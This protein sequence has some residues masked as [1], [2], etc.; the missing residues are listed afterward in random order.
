MTD[1]AAADL[2]AEIERLRA[3]VE[4]LRL[5][6]EAAEAAADHDVLTPALNRRGF[7]AAM[8]QTMAYC[9]RYDAPA[10]LLYLDLDGFKPVNDKHGH[11]AGDALL[12]EVARRLDVCIQPGD[13]AFRIGGDEFVVLLSRVRQRSDVSEV[14]RRLLVSL[15]EPY[16]LDTATVSIGASIGIAFAESSNAD[17]DYLAS[18]AD[19]ALYDAKRSG[20]GTFRFAKD[21]SSLR[22]IA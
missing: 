22:L 2:K 13:D 6:A 5:R 9:I 18:T 17:L 14:A 4:T 1:T 11:Q 19:A 7:V 15:S 16:V 21:A 12:R 10:V 8:Q 3:E 20:R